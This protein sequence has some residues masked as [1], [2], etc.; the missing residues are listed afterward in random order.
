[1]SR[2]ARGAGVGRRSLLVGAGA[3]AVTALGLAACG[4]SESSSGTTTSKAN[5]DD[6]AIASD[7][8]VFGYPLV[9]MDVTRETSAPANRFENSRTLPDAAN[10]SLVRPNQDTLYS[11]AW[12][13]LRTEP[14]VV[15]VPAMEPDRYWLM[16]VMDMWTDVAQ[17]P[18]SVRPQL[19][20]GAVTGPFTYVFTPPGWTGTLPPD[21]TPMPLPTPQAWMLGRIEVNGAADLPAVHAIQDQLKITPLSAWI[22]EPGVGNPAAETPAPA[23]PVDIVA[24]MDGRTYFDRLNAL[25]AIDAPAPAD[26][27]ALQRFAT[28]GIAPGGTADTLSAAQLDAAVTTG[29][30]RVTDYHDASTATINDWNFPGVAGRYG[31]NYDQ[32]AYVARMG[33]GGNVPEDAIYPTYYGTADGPHTTF[34]IH[35]AP[36]R[37]P[38]VDAFWSITAYAAD[39]FLI[40]NPAGVYSVGHQIPVARNPDGSVDILVQNARP[41]PEF[42]T[43]NWLPIPETGKFTLTMRLYAPQPDAINHIWQPPTVTSS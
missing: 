10:R 12:L 36:G 11:K 22:R 30:Q 7:A 8:Y 17:N 43:A 26:A 5:E 37:L 35:F 39:G 6:A 32:R 15:Q 4:K 31:T 33:L 20:S 1:M 9:I 18:S 29:Q 42:A 14:V 13:D 23:D 27:P 24:K 3:L 38:P 41:A 19:K 2:T 25:M 34:H 16:Q 21:L 28:I 40:P